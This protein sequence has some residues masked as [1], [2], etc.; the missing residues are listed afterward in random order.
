MSGS[1]GTADLLALFLHFLSLAAF[2]TGGA[3]SLAS[4]MHRYVVDERGYL[5][6]T[7]FVN[8]IALAQAAPGPNVL[9]VT[10]M[11]YQI[12]GLPGALATT[13]GLTMPALVFPMI[14]SRLGRLPQFNRGLNAFQRGLGPVA[15]GLMAATA[16]LLARAAP[17]AWK[18]AAYVG[19][20]L[21]LLSF[22]RL[23]PLLL[24][25]VAG[26][27]GAFVNWT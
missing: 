16:F 26:I 18:G 17:G 1:L 24:I 20:S 12:A 15:L 3:M 11:G 6:H 2:A 13:L 22:T 4:D 23:P 27:T 10:V 5:S 25:A 8:S 19:A 7:Q 9:F 21:L 14:V